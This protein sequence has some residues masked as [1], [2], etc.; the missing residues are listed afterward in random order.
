MTFGILTIVNSAV[1]L[2]W[3]PECLM[4]R[5]PTIEP[6]NQSFARGCTVDPRG[7]DRIERSDS[8]SATVPSN[9]RRR[10]QTR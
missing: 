10:V 8:N 1:S 6:T 4:D 2:R 5:L 3:M 7:R 9:S